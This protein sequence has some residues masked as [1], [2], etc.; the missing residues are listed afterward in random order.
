MPGASS[1]S[2]SNSGPTMVE[3]ERKGRPSRY[4]QWPYKDEALILKT[5]AAG[6]RRYGQLPQLAELYSALRPR[7][8]RKDVTTADLSKK[9]SN[10]HDKYWRVVTFH[11]PLRL[12]RDVKLQRMS[13]RV[14]G[15]DD[16]EDDDD[17]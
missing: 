14:W 8:I 17:M 1:S 16:G 13:A 15:D 4:T 6:R 12:P 2:N 3:R 11:N 9:I 5:L 10:L 7:F